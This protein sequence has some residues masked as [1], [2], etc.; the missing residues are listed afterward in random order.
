MRSLLFVLL[1]VF[2]SFGSQNFITNYAHVSGKYLVVSKSI[3]I[4]SGDT[5]NVPEG[6]YV[7]FNNLCGITV[8]SG[9]F[10]SA[11][12]TKDSP[13]YFTSVGDT[14]DAVSNNATSPFDWNGIEIKSGA[15]GKFSYCFFAFSTFG[16]TASDSDC[17]HL[18]SCIFS[19][20][21][22]WNFSVSG[23]VHQVQDLQQFSYP[24]PVIASA[25][26]PV[27]LI[28]KDTIPAVLPV[29]KK[30]VLLRR[31]IIQGGVGV[32]LAAA[33]SAMLYKSRKYYSEY[34]SYLPGN[35][36]FDSADPSSR[37]AHF[38]YLRKKYSMFS[39]GY[40]SCFGLLLIDGGVF[41]FTVRF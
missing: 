6:S 13:V 16:V 24:S 30:N 11:S 15:F 25:I 10:L 23:I 19:R 27:P 36:S 31:S 29:H 14:S 12:G 35:S 7:L 18:E 22:Q 8:S 9:G 20:N 37:Q 26:S 1:V 33:G 5:L 4:A 41:A 40:L 17:V 21:G 34:N 39:A 32:L 3:S 28:Q 38:N 2:T